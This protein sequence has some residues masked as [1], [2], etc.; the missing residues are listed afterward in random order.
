MR[1]CSEF[2]N[3]EESQE[4]MINQVNPASSNLNAN[5]SSMSNEKSV[6]MIEL[7]GEQLGSGQY[8]FL[9]DDQQQNANNRIN[10]GGQR[11]NDIEP[12]DFSLI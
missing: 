11:V 12:I 6:E 2:S 4:Q 3:N 7:A 10:F 9:D 8:T 5:E 1:Q